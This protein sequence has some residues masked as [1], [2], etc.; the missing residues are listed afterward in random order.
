M[1]LVLVKDPPVTVAA[2]DDPAS[3]PKMMSRAETL[4]PLIVSVPSPP[5]L[6]PTTKLDAIVHVPLLISAVP[7]P[8][9]PTMATSVLKSVPPVRARVAVSPAAAFTYVY[10]YVLVPELIVVV[11][12]ETVRSAAVAAVGLIPAWAAKPRMAIAT[13]DRRWQAR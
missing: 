4:P 9:Y 13:S 6:F 10:S 8:L 7:L 1:V 2:A 3:A 5:E 11:P 12:L